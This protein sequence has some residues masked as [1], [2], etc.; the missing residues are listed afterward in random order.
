MTVFSIINQLLEKK[1]WKRL[2][3]TTYI[4]INGVSARSYSSQGQIRSA[5][6]SLKL[7]EGEIIKELFKEYPVFIFD[8]VLSELDEKRRKYIFDGVSDRQIIITAC[9]EDKNN[10]KAEKIINVSGGYYVSSRG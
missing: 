8:D 7:A 4:K 1:I 10:L 9:E 6:L 5:V 3:C 2:S